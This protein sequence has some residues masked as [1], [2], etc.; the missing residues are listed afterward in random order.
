V[1]IAHGLVKSPPDPNAKIQIYA[2]KSKVRDGGMGHGDLQQLLGTVGEQL[3][4][5]VVN[6]ARVDPLY[7]NLFDWAY[8][9]DSNFS[10]MGNRREELTEKVLQNLTAQT[11]LA[12]TRERR[13]VEIWFVTEQR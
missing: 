6:E 2:E 12:F 9:P 5:Y 13:S 3:N 1:I 10:K 8:Y 11:G 4:V 7:A